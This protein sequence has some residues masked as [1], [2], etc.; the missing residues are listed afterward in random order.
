LKITVI[1][2]LHRV[3]QFNK[4]R[5]IDSQFLS[6]FFWRAMNFLN[7]TIARAAASHEPVRPSVDGS[8][9]EVRAG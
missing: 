5:A 2:P 6:G 1:G 7:S 9:D 4:A 8:R 3:E